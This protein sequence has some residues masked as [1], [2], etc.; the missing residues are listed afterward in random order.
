MLGLISKLGHLGDHQN[1]SVPKSPP[2][3]A[4]LV[5][6]DLAVVP[7]AYLSPPLGLS[8]AGMVLA[9]EWCWRRYGAG[10]GLCS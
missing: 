10:V 9:Q 5:F 4:A 7:V 2:R 6:L 1:L 8:V 3:V